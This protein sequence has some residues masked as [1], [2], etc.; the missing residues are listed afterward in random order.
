MLEPGDEDRVVASAFKGH[1]G[2]QVPITQRGD[3]ADPLSTMP[4]FEGQESLASGRP[5]P[6]VVC[7]VINA[8]FVHVDQ[9]S[10]IERGGVGAKDF[11]RRLVALAIAIALFLRVKPSLL[12]PR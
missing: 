10:G 8:R 6:R 12:R 9:G 11:A 1:G 3:E 5:A 7:A 2:Y 4:R